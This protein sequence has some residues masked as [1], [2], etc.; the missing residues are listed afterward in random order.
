[1]QRALRS[2]T[3]LVALVAST[4]VSSLV[5]AQ[6]LA[7]LPDGALGFL[8]AALVVASMALGVTVIERALFWGAW[9]EPR[10]EPKP[11]SL[12]AHSKLMAGHAPLPLTMCV[13][14]G[15]LLA[16]RLL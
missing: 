3:Y 12:R 7:L 9:L 1:M 16:V 8:L 14:L 4:A 11:A 5:V 13:V 10:G 2:L 15:A 6:I